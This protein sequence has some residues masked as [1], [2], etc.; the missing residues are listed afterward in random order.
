LPRWRSSSSRRGA[1]ASRRRLSFSRSGPPSRRLGPPS[2]ASV[3]PERKRRA[4]FSE[5]A[6]HWRR[7]RPPSSS[8]TWRSRGSQASWSKRVCP[9][10]SC[11]RPTRKKTPLSSSCS[12]QRPP[13]VPP[14]SRRRGRL[15]VSCLSCLSP[16]GLILL[17][18]APNLVCVLVFRPVEG[19]RDF[20]DPGTGHPDGL[21]LFSAGARRAVGRRPQ[22]MPGY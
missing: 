8:G 22:G 15:R 13:R 21:Q 2:S 16:V 5:S 10:K 14:S 17:G 4:D 12:R 7:R 20:D 3:R 19:S 6:S 11:S 18:S 9:M 1:R